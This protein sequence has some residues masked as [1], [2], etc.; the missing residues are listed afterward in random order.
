M[1]T[2]GCSGT[3]TAGP[4][5]PGDGRSV[6]GVHDEDVGLGVVGDAGRDR[7]E[8]PTFDGGHS[9]VADDQQ[10]GLDLLGQIQQHMDLAADDRPHF[11]VL[12][13]AASARSRAP[14]NLS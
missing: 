9:Q 10:V 7:S 3:P 12:A 8:Q 4:T 5:A 11:D 2:S 6:P 14:C 13:P 1:S